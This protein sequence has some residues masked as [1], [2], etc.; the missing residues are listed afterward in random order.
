MDFKIK[1]IGEPPADPESYLKQLYK[2]VDEAALGDPG[3]CEEEELFKFGELER[4]N[5]ET[6]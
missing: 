3:E 1:F 4:G 6:L 5:K 2:I